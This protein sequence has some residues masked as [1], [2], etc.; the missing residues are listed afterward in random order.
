MQGYYPHFNDHNRGNSM[1]NRTKL[2]LEYE[3]S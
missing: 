2:Y 1:Y 3:V